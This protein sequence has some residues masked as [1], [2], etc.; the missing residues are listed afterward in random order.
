MFGLYDQNQNFIQEYTTDE[1]GKIYI[2]DLLEGI[3]YIK[4]LSTLDG[5]HLLDG[6]MEVNVKNNVLS[7]FKVTNRLKVEVPKTGVNELFYTILFSSFCLVLGMVL[8]N[9]DKDH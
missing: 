8:C 4:E 2:P 3:Y 7:S 6:F 1:N 9:Y 5:Y